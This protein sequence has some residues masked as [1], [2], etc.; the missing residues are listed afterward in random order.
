MGDSPAGTIGADKFLVIPMEW[1]K[2]SFEVQTHGKGM[3]PI[4]EMVESYIQDWN[5]REGMCFL[6]IPHASASLTIS[7]SYDPSSRQDVEAF[8]EQAVPENQPWY[9][10]TLEGPD[11]SPSH[12]R[13][14]LTQPSL[15]IPVDNGRLSMGIWQGIFLFE[16]R[17]RAQRRQIEIRCLKVK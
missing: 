4:T 1:L 11:D 5:V 15:S 8:Y 10:H 17:S 13:A 9:R 12:I 6:Y 7:E 14:T 2:D 16:H 3:L